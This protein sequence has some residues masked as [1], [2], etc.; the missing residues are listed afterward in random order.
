M[1]EEKVFLSPKVRGFCVGVRRTGQSE[2][3]DLTPSSG[4]D[5]Q[6]L[7]TQ[8]QVVCP[9]EIFQVPLPRKRE[10]CSFVHT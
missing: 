6:L 3:K 9:P 10:T 2:G 1:G 5:A 7:A 8:T 4:M